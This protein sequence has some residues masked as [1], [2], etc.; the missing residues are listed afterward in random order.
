M[1]GISTLCV[2]LNCQADSVVTFVDR[3]LGGLSGEESGGLSSQLRIA[4]LPSNIG[5]VDSQN[6]QI[7]MSPLS[8]YSFGTPRQGP[9]SPFGSGE[10]SYEEDMNFGSGGRKT[11]RHR[12]QLAK[13]I[14]KTKKVRKAKKTKKAKKVKKV[15]VL[16]GG[17]KSRRYR[18]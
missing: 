13:K 14:K 3:T 17:K 2:V 10:G 15:F 4:A 11:R 1:M 9:G 8:H 6:S 18:K 5:R 12:R 16:K 7:A